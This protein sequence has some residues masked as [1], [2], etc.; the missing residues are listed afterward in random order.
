VQHPKLI[1]FVDLISTTQTHYKINSIG[2]NPLYLGG[3]TIL[4]PIHLN[5]QVIQAHF[6]VDTSCSLCFQFSKAS[7]E[8]DVH[9]LILLQLSTPSA[10]GF[11]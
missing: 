11:T 6:L 1:V 8:S 7:S 4:V 3:S 9:E 10:I 5:A 2:V